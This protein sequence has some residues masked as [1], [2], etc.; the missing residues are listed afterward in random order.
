MHNTQFSKKDFE[1]IPLP[2]KRRFNVTLFKHGDIKQDEAIITNFT[3]HR[4]QKFIVLRDSN[5][6]V[7]LILS[8]ESLWDKLKDISLES[9]LQVTGVVVARPP[10]QVNAKMNTGDIEVQRLKAMAHNLGH[11]LISRR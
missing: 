3:V 7:Q 1:I 6:T 9:V 10:G 4:M 11:L 8:D 2:L 5:G